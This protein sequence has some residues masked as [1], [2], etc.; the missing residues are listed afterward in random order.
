M[1]L[2]TSHPLGES[3][4]HVPWPN[5][6]TKGFLTNTNM[7]LSAIH[8]LVSSVSLVWFTVL[9]LG[10]ALGPLGSFLLRFFSKAAD[11]FSTSNKFNLY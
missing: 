8:S 11:C 6:D 7:S 4:Y 2:L 3:L 1:K 9:K 5:R 10:G